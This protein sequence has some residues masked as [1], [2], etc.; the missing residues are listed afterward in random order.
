[1]R[2]IICVLLLALTMTVS[3]Y[4][5]GANYGYGVGYKAGKA[6]VL[7]SSIKKR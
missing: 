5:M 4:Y 1:M 3:S 2:L 6:D 7:L